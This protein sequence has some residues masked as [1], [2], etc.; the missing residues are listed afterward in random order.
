MKAI[1]ERGS[2]LALVIGQTKK[3]S[4]NPK[5]PIY[6]SELYVFNNNGDIVFKSHVADESHVIH[7]ETRQNTFSIIKDAA[8]EIYENIN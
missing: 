6:N 5:Y 4:I 1:F 2:K 3:G 7:L 8:V